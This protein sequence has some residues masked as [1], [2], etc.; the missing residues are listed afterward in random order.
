MIDDYSLWFDRKLGDIRGALTL[1]KEVKNGKAVKIFE[2]LPAAS[3]Q[4]GYSDGGLEDWI[5]GKGPTPM[6]VHWLSTKREKLF[7]AEPYGTPF[8]PISTEQGSRIIVGPGGVQR[9]SCGLHYENSSPGTAGCTALL[10]NTQNRKTKAKALFDY[11]DKLC[12]Q[13]IKYIPYHVL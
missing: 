5:Q 7:S 8:Y 11:L 10:I 2:R 9:D 12:I 4:R 3:G 6:G 13:G 1:Q